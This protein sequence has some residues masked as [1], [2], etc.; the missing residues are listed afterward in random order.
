M[1]KAVDPRGG[2]LFGAAAA[3]DMA[4]H[5]PLAERL[6]PRSL[7]E[8]VGQEKILGPGRAL[9][10]LIERRELPSIILW[11]PP[12]SGKTTLAR[13][14]A[15][16]VEAEFESLSAVMSGVKELRAV[17]ERAGERRKYH[18]QRT[19]L[20]ID[21][22]HRFNK[23][24]QDALLPHVESGLLTLIGATTENPSFEVNAALL[25]RAK[26]FV[27]EPL[28]PAA[29]VTVLERA[30]SDAERGLGGRGVAAPPLVLDAVART[31]YGDARK[32]LTTLEIACDLAAQ[33]GEQELSP[34]LIEEAAQQKMLLYDK[35]G[36]E[37]FNV[38][39]AFIK[40]LRGSDPDAA[41]YWMTRMLEAGEP[42]RFI[43][44]RMVI[45]ASED[46][47]NADPRAL[48]VAVNALSAFELVGL[49]EGVLP[50][51]QAAIYL[52]CAPKSNTVITAYAKARADVRA[53]GPLAVPAKLRNAST[54]LM[55][56]LG[57]GEGYKYPH[58]FSGNYVAESYL[59]DEL[60]GRLYCEL[61]GQGE[62]IAMRERLLARRAKKS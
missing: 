21:E 26:V 16:H 53:H 20:F 50:M 57:Y 44:R 52:A 15:K 14:L 18:R 54:G 37:H 30:I 28:T 8:I 1:A 38:V 47:G 3:R 43:L 35:A 4:E 40:S 13:V 24:Q 25:S 36:E 58:D 17:V 33:N 10:R 45:L 46:I 5:A 42:P 56:S 23:A 22:I 48:E 39:S 19:V 62:E 55:K 41:V 27:L 49:P 60:T 31:S 12:G 6:R 34:A 29:L 32:A 59:P 51:T 61:S 9:R 7:D 2:D 11:G